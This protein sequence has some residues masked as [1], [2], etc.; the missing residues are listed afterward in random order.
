MALRHTL[1]FWS[2]LPLALP[3]ALYIR[4]TAPRFGGA[5]GPTS[6]TA[7]PEGNGVPRSLVGVGDSIIAGVGTSALEHALIGQVADALG[8]RLDA[9]VHWK[10]IGRS[11]ATTRQVV[12]E[13]APQLPTTPAD[14]VIV[15]VGVNDVT[16]PSSRSDFRQALGDLLA[17]LERHSPTAAIAILGLPPMHRFPLLPQPLR[18]TLGCRARVLD[19]IA[20]GVVAEHRNARHAAVE[21]EVRP[22]AFADDGYHP[23]EASC[24]L[25][26]ELVTNALL[27]R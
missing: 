1:G 17:T 21:V 14:H 22:G 19:H 9:P 5:P 6:G 26:A 7:N 25:L 23:S 12:D 2:L 24:T 18:A 10:A 16:K 15:S 13:L 20:R 27:E 3:Q 4:R 8:D 11:G